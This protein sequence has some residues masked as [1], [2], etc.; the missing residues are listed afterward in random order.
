MESERKIV[1]TLK[2]IQT[3]QSENAMLKSENEKLKNAPTLQF[4]DFLGSSLEQDK[5][6]KKRRRHSL[7]DLY[8][9]SDSNSSEENIDSQ[10]PHSKRNL[11]NEDSSTRSR[12]LKQKL[13]RK[14][15]LVAGS[16]S[17]TPF[18]DEINH[19]LPKANINFKELESNS[20]EYGMAHNFLI[21]SEDQFILESR[22]PNQSP[23]KVELGLP[24]YDLALEYLDAF[25]TFLG[26]CFYFINVGRFKCSL[27]K[28][29]SN[30]SP[31]TAISREDV[32]FYTSLLLVL[33]IGKMYHA[34]QG[35]SFKI[36]DNSEESESF[37]GLGFF[38]K[39][40]YII[41][42]AFNALQMGQCTVENVQ[43]LLLYSFYHQV[44]D[45]SSGH[46]LIS[47]ITMRT[48]LVLGMHK[49]LGKN[50]LNRYELEH[51][52]RLWWTLYAVDRY[53]SAKSGFPL[54]IPDET[55]TT[56]LPADIPSSILTSDACRYD[57][58]PNSS[59][60]TQFIRISQI[61]SSMIVRLYQNKPSSDII[62]IILSILSEVY[63]WRKDLPDS[64]KVDYTQDNVKT[65]RSISNIH[66]EYFRCINLT[67][68]PLLLY[69]VR[70][71]LRSRN[72]KPG[73]ID[74]SKNS[75]DII[76]LLNASLQASIQTLRSHNYLLGQTLLAKFGY[77]DREYITSA[78]ST[79]VLFNVAFG[80][81][82]SASQ[83]INIG[84]NLL[85][86]MANAG[87][88]NAGCRR[89]QT[90]HLIHTFEKHGIP[91]H[92]FPS[93][94]PPQLPKSEPNTQIPGSADHI[95]NPGSSSSSQSK[96]EIMVNNSFHSSA[97]M[98]SKDPDSSHFK[99]DY[100]MGK[101]P[102]LLDPTGLNTQ[103]GVF[104][105][106]M[107]NR[108]NTSEQKDERNE[109]APLP[110]P[111][112]SRLHQE[113]HEDLNQYEKIHLPPPSP[114]GL[115]TSLLSSPSTTGSS[116][117]EAENAKNLENCKQQ[118]LPTSEYKSHDENVP[119]E[120]YPQNFML[121]NQNGPDMFDLGNVNPL[122]FFRHTS[123]S[124]GLP[125][126]LFGQD[127]QSTLLQPGNNDNLNRSEEHTSE[128]QSLE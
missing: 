103:G 94:T 62:P 95:Q 105:A 51:R 77:L 24:S 78:M 15:S 79:L 112:L 121:L 116:L 29:Y 124:L 50:T 6:P 38:N 75:K 13:I 31:K 1:V 110:L 99:K 71:R 123:N 52:R 36:T 128:L 14:S 46:Y 49:D 57:E 102:P 35:K 104:N 72:K 87:N 44:V 115:T 74:L 47:G 65:S 113:P 86:E 85:S 58:F 127:A 84:L 60:I 61:F 39:S 96:P 59:Y 3:L 92:H 40:T 64:L 11:Q 48:A 68:R 21:R 17:L 30:V 70:K 107:I 18:G 80:V 9:D 25:N 4:R 73:P 125:M 27:Y 67:I 114:Q 97:T 37:P 55:I 23:M 81:H 66:S 53:C 118:M 111:S 91:A 5:Q 69:F 88:K 34:G 90:M 12:Q 41:N 63:Q 98:K 76:T 28:V 45:A 56:E 119:S 83:H 54:S 26:E 2:Y 32:L 120:R 106:G 117:T 126:N 82:G 20:M 22:I 33:A 109:G 93:M 7:T 16:T 101:P 10:S 108:A 42:F 89:E 8:E 19:I 122:S 43:A 100:T